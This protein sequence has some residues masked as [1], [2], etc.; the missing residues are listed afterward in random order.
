M[1]EHEMMNN[2]THSRTIYN[3]GYQR[4]C[5]LRKSRKGCEGCDAFTPREQNNETE[6]GNGVN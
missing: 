2:C 5:E 3:A 4:V 1:N 6:D